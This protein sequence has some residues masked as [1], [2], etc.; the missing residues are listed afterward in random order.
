M[1]SILALAVGAAAIPNLQF[2]ETEF[3]AVGKFKEN[4]GGVVLLIVDALK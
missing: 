4:A 1:K 3:A 2:S